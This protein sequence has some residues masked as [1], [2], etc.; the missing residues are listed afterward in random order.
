MANLHGNSVENRWYSMS[1]SEQLANIGAEVGRA[2]KWQGKD[3]QKFNGATSRAIELL[4]L[5]LE[6]QRWKG[7]LF[8]IGRVKE[9]F[10]D[11]ISGRNEYGTDL[12][13]LENYFYP[14]MGFVARQHNTFQ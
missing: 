1:L 4:N 7:H 10:Y 5:T 6:D 2:A 13:D 8:E 3:D 14:F 9:L 12:K 11:S